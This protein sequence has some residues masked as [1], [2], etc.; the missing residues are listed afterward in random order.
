MNLLLPVLL[1]LMF[2]FANARAAQSCPS[3]K[4]SETWRRCEYASDC[5]PLYLRCE[6]ES[7]NKASEAMVRNWLHACGA[8]NGAAIPNRHVTCRNHFCEIDLKFAH[9]CLK[10]SKF[11]FEISPDKRAVYKTKCNYTIIKTFQV[12]SECG[13]PFVGKP[14]IRDLTVDEKKVRIT[15]GK[16]D[17]AEIDITSDKL[18]CL[19]SD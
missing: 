12:I 6:S 2:G 18:R 9:E 13:K 19:G 17:F 10:D 15:Y 16:H 1:T 4:I 3:I 14:E 8:C 5:V 11:Y 7:A